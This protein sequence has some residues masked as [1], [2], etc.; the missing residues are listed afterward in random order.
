MSKK[1]PFCAIGNDEFCEPVGETIVCPLCGQIHPIEYGYKVN[2]DGT[3]TPSKIL[4]YYKCGNDAYLAAVNG[5]SV[6]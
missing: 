5:R 2:A 1:I 6:M 3:K 4:G